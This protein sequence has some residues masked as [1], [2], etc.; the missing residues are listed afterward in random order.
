MMHEIKGSVFL[1]GSSLYRYW[2][3]S[4]MYFSG[5]NPM[6]EYFTKGQQLTTMEEEKDMGANV[7]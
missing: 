4:L 6:F 7:S 5:H 1:Y 3:V 2:T